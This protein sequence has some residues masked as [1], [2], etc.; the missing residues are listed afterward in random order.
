MP[1]PHK[2]VQVLIQVS[3]ILAGD[4]LNGVH[5]AIFEHGHLG[6]V[7]LHLDEVQVLG[8]E[9]IGTVPVEII[10]FSSMELSSTQSV[11][12]YGPENSMVSGDEPSCWLPTCSTKSWRRGYRPR[13]AMVRSRS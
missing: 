5:L 3:K 8:G 1:P 6:V 2:G 7:I 13:T 4:L 11:M 12:M 9:G 10:L